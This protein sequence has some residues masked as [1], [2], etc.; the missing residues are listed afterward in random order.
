MIKKPTIKDYVVVVSGSLSLMIMVIIFVTALMALGWAVKNLIGATI[1]DPISTLTALLIVA[2]IGSLLAFVAW[3]LE[4]WRA[5]WYRVKKYWESKQIESLYTEQQCPVCGYYCLGKG[6]KGCIDKPSI[7][8]Q[9]KK[10]R[11]W[12]KSTK[13]E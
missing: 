11:R 2:S 10:S 5:S 12:L 3:S 13:S 6:G 8:L 9:R 7:H 1:E 4:N